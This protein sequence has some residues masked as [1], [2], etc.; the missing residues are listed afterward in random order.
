VGARLSLTNIL[1]SRPECVGRLCGGRL[2]CKFSAKL[3]HN[4]AAKPIKVATHT[5]WKCSPAFHRALCL[6]DSL[7]N[8]T[9]HG[10]ADPLPA[11]MWRPEPLSPC[12]INPLRPACEG[13][14]DLHCVF[15][16]TILLLGERPLVVVDTY[17]RLASCLHRL[18]AWSVRTVS[19]PRT[20]R[21]NLFLWPRTHVR[22]RLL[23][24]ECA[25][26]TPS[27]AIDSNLGT[28]FHDAQ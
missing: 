27:L 4:Q 22:A 8:L 20:C 9:S 10:C 7:K 3:R 18:V 6:V 16:R 5:S 1:C 21:P 17:L 24:K 28:G 12:H 13:L 15:V 25:S 14:Q 26:I 23:L 11:K 19:T 2:P